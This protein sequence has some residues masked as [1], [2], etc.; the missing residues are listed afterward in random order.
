MLDAGATAQNLHATEQD[1]DARVAEL[2]GARGV[3]PGK[4]YASLQQAN[5]LGELE[6]SLTEEKTFSWLL[7]Q[8]TVTESAA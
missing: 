2:A 1:L 8:S 4:L 7:G 6:R 3:E 5:R